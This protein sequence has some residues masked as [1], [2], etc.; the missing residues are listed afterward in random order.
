MKLSIADFFLDLIFPVKC[1]G[2]GQKEEK[3]HICSYC[4]ENIKLKIGFECAFCLSRTLNGETCPFCAREHWLDYLWV[5][6]DYQDSAVKRAIWAF[7]YKFISSLKFPLTGLLLKFLKE[8]KK[9]E[10]LKNYRQDILIVPVPLHRLRLNWRSYNQSELLALELGKELGIAVDES[11]LVRTENKKPQAEVE[12]KEKRVSNAVGVFA[13]FNPEKITDRTVL[14][15]DDVATTASTLDECA[16]VLKESGAR[17][18]IGL[19]VARG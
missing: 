3:E 6:A 15:V 14:L 8:K 4:F 12:D 16:K 1:L 7:K 9:D 18:V 2:C 13:C 5:A 11:V 17:K 10:L 19:V